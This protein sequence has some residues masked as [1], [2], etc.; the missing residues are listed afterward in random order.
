MHTELKGTLDGSGLRI[1]IVAAKFNE[2]ITTRLLAGALDELGKLGVKPENV[3]V[4]W[5]PGAFDMPLVAK[6]FAESGKMD[7]IV[8]LGAVIRG[9]TDHYHHVAEG[10]AKGIAS[11]ALQS[12]VPV[13]F[14]VL[15][16][17]SL[18]QAI[19]RAGAKSGNKGAETARAA[20]ETCHLLRRI[21]GA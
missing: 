12:G 2:F 8:C 19:N 3:T 6:A 15:T 11:V 16:V 10:V 18:E 17:D 5:T 20:I 14:G 13:L 7:V 9:E 1:A 21:R 4:A